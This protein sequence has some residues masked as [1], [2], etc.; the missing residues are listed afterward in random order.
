MVNRHEKILK[1]LI[2][3]GVQIKA[4]MRYHLIRVRMAIINKSTN[5]CWL[6]KGN[7]FAMLVGMQIGAAIVESNEEIPQKVKNGPAL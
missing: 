5:E 6:R 2:S 3:R 1:S 7:P 4:T